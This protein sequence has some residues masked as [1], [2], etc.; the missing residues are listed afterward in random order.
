MSPLSGLMQTDTSPSSH[1]VAA[2]DSRTN[3]LHSSGEGSDGRDHS[4][5]RLSMP[6]S[7]AVRPPAS[8]GADQALR[9]ISGKASAYHACLWTA[10]SITTPAVTYRQIATRSLRARATIAVLRCR[11]PLRF[12]RA[13][14]HRV[15]AE[16]G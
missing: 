13:S 4:S 1:P 9:K 10:P 14:N 8:A 5:D 2:R 11:P 7:S 3:I 6:N 15:S 12:T 16:L